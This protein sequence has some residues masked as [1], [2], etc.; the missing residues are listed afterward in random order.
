MIRFL[1]QALVVLVCWV[2]VP[3]GWAADSNSSY[4]V[5]LDLTDG[6]RVVGTPRITSLLVPADFAKVAVSVLT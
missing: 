5:V 1:A 3:G 6:S 4:R 2:A